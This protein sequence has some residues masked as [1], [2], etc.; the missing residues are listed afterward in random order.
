[1]EALRF[2]RGWGSHIFRHLAHRWRHGCQ[3]YAPAAFYPPGRF[4]VRISVRGWSTPGPSTSSGTRTGDLP[5]CSIVPQP[6]TLPRAPPHR[7]HISYLLLWCEVQPNDGLHNLHSSTSTRTLAGMEASE[8]GQKSHGSTPRSVIFP[9]QHTSHFPL[10]SSSNSVHT[11]AGSERPYLRRQQVLLV[12]WHRPAE[13]KQNRE[14]K[15][16]NLK[17]SHPNFP[18]DF[19]PWSQ[20]SSATISFSRIIV[21]HLFNLV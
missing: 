5:A 13:G 10:Q 16:E 4:L 17:R 18:L 20:H 2:A 9:L 21:L 14:Q 3:P 15:T 12:C 1:V 11:N 7:M 6:I 8:R 19:F